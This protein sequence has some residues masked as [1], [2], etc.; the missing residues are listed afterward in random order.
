MNENFIQ[1]TIMF[2]TLALLLLGIFTSQA[3]EAVKLF[4]FAMVAIGVIAIY[5]YIVIE[6]KIKK[7]EG[8]E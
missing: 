4:A 3:T 8:V 5:I 7:L 2:L 6:P 1:T